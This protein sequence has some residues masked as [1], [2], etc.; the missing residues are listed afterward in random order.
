MRVAS[1]NQL[2]ETDPSDFLGWSW[3]LFYHFG[4]VVEL[5]CEGGRDVVSQH[6]SADGVTP[7]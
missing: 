1:A 3:I 2:G 6:E 4:L 7:A 5:R